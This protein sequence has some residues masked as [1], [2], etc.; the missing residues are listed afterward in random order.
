[1][2]I[3]QPTSVSFQSGQDGTWTVSLSPAEDVT[4]WTVSCVIRAY[5][6]GT[7]LVTKTTSSGITVED[8]GNGV[9]LVEFSSSDLTLAHGPGAYL[10]QL[11]R[12]NSGY[13]YPITDP[14]PLIL[15]PA[16]ATAYPTLTNM[17]EYYASVG[18]VP[19][20]TDDESTQVIFHLA[21]AE[22]LL[23]RLCGREFTYKSRTFYLDGNGSQELQIPEF[24]VQSVT[25][26]YVDRGGY[27]GQG[28]DAFDTDTLLTAG[29]D[30][31]LVIDDHGVNGW[32]KTGLLRR[33]GTVWPY[34]VSRKPGYLSKQREPCHGCIKLTAVTGYTLVPFDLKM[35]IFDL[36]NF[37]RSAAA[38]GRLLQSEGGEGYNYS[39]G[40][41]DEEA[42]R[43]GSVKNI[44]SIYKSG[45]DY[46]G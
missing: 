25:S 21:A 18:G 28:T 40:G 44:V 30:Y 9:F 39:L 41:L 29:T 7:A 10:I 43:L 12:T 14:S 5:A 26:V 4:G 11:M 24:P 23:K 32:S 33:V 16:S 45:A 3:A 2:A 22:S 8:T 17:G 42:K 35:A 13:E 38:D 46:V 27:Y 19:T 36:V 31:Y 37:Y 15:R 20:L 34:N 6:G 1:V